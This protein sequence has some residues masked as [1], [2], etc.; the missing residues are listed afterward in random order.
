MRGADGG[1]A[2][3][4]DWRTVLVAVALPAL[5]FVGFEGAL[6]L[7]G[8]RPVLYEEDP[9]VGFAATVPLFVEESSTNGPVMVATARNK[10]RLFNAQR[11]SKSKAA[12]TYRIFCLGGST[13][14]GR[15][16]DDTT[17]FCGWLRELLPAVDDNRRWEVIN[18]GGVSYASYRTALLAEEL[19]AYEPD[20]FIVY[21]GHNEFLEKR[22][23]SGLIAMPPA[24]RGVA[25]RAGRT[26]TYALLRGAYRG[27]RGRAEGEV[28]ERTSRLAAEVQTLLDSS[29]GPDA[30]ERDDELSEQILSHY[31]FNLA[32]IVDIARSAGAETILVTPASNLRHASAFKSEHR[33]GLTAAA[34]EPWQALFEQAG[35]A[36]AEGALTTA[37]VA[38]DRALAI[39]D[40][41]AHSHFLRGR[42]LVRLERFDDARAAFERARDE[43]VCPLRALTGTADIVDEVARDRRVSVV[44]FAR[45]V[46]DRAVH[47]IP[48][49]DLFL[50]HVHPTIAANRELALLL[51]GALGDDGI[52]EPSAAWDDSTVSVVSQRVEAKLDRDAHGRAL[53]NLSKVL[54][55]AGKLDEA[56]R[57]A[58]LA[59][60]TAPGLPETH[61]QAGLTAQLGGRLDEAIGHYRRA[62]RLAPNAVTAHGNLAAALEKNGETLQAILHYRRAIALLG[63]EESAYKKQLIETLIELGA[64]PDG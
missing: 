11:F 39:D 36:E 7:F 62:L 15:P 22:T 37:L 60:E 20:L 5:F 6:H 59:A 38:I 2:G 33:A 10:L 32:R 53:L 29:V 52:L 24:L 16:Y 64:T 55:W 43:D 14:H 28:T 12:G 63:S 48:G 27:L 58:V 23:Y 42:I 31:R 35:E 21:S 45:W 26:R 19:I 9:Y 54:G 25:A 44:D 8:V 41:H 47:G 13:T 49:D 30:Y 3:R 18:A 61:Y 17:S 4:R 34:L 57:L 40:R 50:D 51:L 46:D 56:A 1:K